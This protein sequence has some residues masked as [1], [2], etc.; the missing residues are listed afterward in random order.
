[1]KPWSL[2]F[3]CCW[4]GTG[5]SQHSHCCHPYEA[6]GPLHV[7]SRPADP[8]PYPPS[9]TK[10]QMKPHFAGWPHWGPR[11]PSLLSLQDALT[12]SQSEFVARPTLH[13]RVGRRKELGGKVPSGKWC[14][15]SSITPRG[16]SLGAWSRVT[17]S[18]SAS[19]EDASSLP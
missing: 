13:P 2:H 6:E 8:R 4:A 18:C 16:P 12:H 1:M 9:P 14:R 11:S 17:C 19:C 15:S 10:A 5:S 7:V 3:P